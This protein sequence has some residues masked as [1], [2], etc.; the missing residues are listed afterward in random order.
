M[1]KYLA[2]AAA[3]ALI[4]IAKTPI[5][6]YST[7]DNKIITVKQADRIVTTDMTSSKYLVWDQEGNTYEN[8]DTVWFLKWNSSDVQGQMLQGKKVNIKTSGIRFT[9]L[10]WY[11]NIITAFP[12]E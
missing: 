12:A 9:W 10:S 5:F 6:Y 11:P 8:T 3:I 2:I 7:I 4:Y 1:K